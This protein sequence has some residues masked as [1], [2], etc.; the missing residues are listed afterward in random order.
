MNVA[1]L[2]HRGDVGLERFGGA[3]DGAGE[4][5]FL[6]LAYCCGELGHRGPGG[7]SDSVL[8][9]GRMVR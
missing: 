6:I 4:A 7:Q 1:R 3:G 9:T 5:Q 2:G 8:S